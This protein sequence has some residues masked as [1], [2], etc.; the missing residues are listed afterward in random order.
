MC[1]LS[2]TLV[3]DSFASVQIALLSKH[4]DFKTQ[5]KVGVTATILSG[6]IGI[7]MAVKGFG[8][9]SLV[10]QYIAGSFFRSLFL[11]LLSTWRPRLV[12]ASVRFERCSI[13]APLCWRP[14]CSI[15]SLKTSIW[16][17]SEAVSR[18]P[19]WDCIPALA[20]SS[21]C[22]R[23]ISRWLLSGR[24]PGVFYDPGRSIRLKRAMRSAAT[25]LAFV[26]F[27]FMVSLAL[28]AKPLVYLLLTEKWAALIPWLQ[29][30][31]VA[32]LPYPFHALHLNLLKA[33]G[34]SH[35]YFRLE[36]LKK[37]LM[38]VTIAIT[39]RWGVTGLIWG[40]IVLSFLCYNI[41]SF[42]TKRLI[43]YTFREQLADLAPY[44]AIS[45]LMGTSLCG[46]RF[47]PFMGDGLLLLMGIVMG[48]GLYI[49][50][51]YILG[52]SAFVETTLVLVRPLLRGR[53]SLTQG[54]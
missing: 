25:M 3:I 1:A 46:L 7:T 47:V 22:R 9:G 16:W 34:C 29:L 49:A 39:Y 21:S 10:G 32:S 38:V 31:C 12:S 37:I 2:V 23:Q 42:Y 4:I 24:I 33:M 15:R 26:Y 53:L 20:E 40:Q 11:W 13:S 50:L 18:P 17:L 41:N 19:S 51:S 14:I 6:A 30:L 48:G 52:L 45:I 35:L 5:L 27:P 54:T 8:V 44:A 43:H 36:V 28:L